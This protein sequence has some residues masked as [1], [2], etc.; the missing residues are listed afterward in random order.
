MDKDLQYESNASLLSSLLNIPADELACQNM[1]DILEAPLSIKGIG[2]KKADK[3]YVVKEV[4][5]RIMEERPSDAP[6]IITTPAVIQL[7]AGK[8]L[9]LQKGWSRQAKSWTSPF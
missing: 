6:V 3:L 7:P 2:N 5:R 9:P 1:S 8:I 4:V